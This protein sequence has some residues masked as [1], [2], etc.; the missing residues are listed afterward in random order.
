ME[1]IREESNLSFQILQKVG[2]I[3]LLI[4]LHTVYKHSWC[5]LYLDVLDTYKN[6]SHVFLYWPLWLRDDTIFLK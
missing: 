5:I 1:M 6:L 3:A 2:P 4:G